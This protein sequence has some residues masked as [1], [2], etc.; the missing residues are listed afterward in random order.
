MKLEKINKSVDLQKGYHSPPI[1]PIKAR[2]ARSRKQ[3]VS[4]KP[5]NIAASGLVEHR[6]RLSPQRSD[7][8][9]AGSD[10]GSSSS[11]T[12]QDARRRHTVGKEPGSDG[13]YKLFDGINREDKFKPLAVY[14][15]L[16][17]ITN[18][19][20]LDDFKHYLFNLI[21]LYII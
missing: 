14:S 3:G 18:F 1:S 9:Y 15:I 12:E 4:T 17:L 8:G 21:F 16:W 2:Q 5:S 10:A 13:V 20:N 19:E 6:R 11:R 7:S